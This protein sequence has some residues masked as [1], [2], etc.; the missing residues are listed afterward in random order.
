MNTIADIIDA[1]ADPSNYN[2][3]MR[4][5][6][7]LITPRYHVEAAVAPVSQYSTCAAS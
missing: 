2:F 6:E 4:N 7:L 1:L 5:D 3:D